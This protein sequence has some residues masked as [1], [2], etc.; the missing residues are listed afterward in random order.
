MKTSKSYTCLISGN[1]SKLLFLEDLLT[2]VEK[3]SLFVFNQGKSSWAFYNQK[4][5]Y[6]ICRQNFP[7]INSKI[8]QNFISLYQLQPG[9]KS[10][11][12]P[13]SPSIYIDQNFNVRKIRQQNF[14]IIG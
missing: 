7:S 1:K 12:T 5:L 2:E 13:I 4:H 11:K 14:Q 6:S 3:L 8:L 10:A 9:K